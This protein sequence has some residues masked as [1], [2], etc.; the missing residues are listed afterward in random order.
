MRANLERTRGLVYSGTVLVELARA[1]LSREEAYRLVQ[2]HA[3]RAFE[4][5]ED[6][7]AL[8]GGDPEIRKHLDAATLAACFDLDHHLR[9]VERIFA[10]AFAEAVDDAPAGAR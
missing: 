4:K 7:A 6:F 10:R 2:G 3:M 1:G 8:L 5:G 9:H